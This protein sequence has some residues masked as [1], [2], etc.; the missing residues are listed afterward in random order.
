M[1]IN[2]S[3]DAICEPST[4]SDSFDEFIRTRN[5]MLRSQANVGESISARA[6]RVWRV[7]KELGMGFDGS[8]AKAENELSSLLL[9]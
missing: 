7:C 8:D 6:N 2:S 5:T 9:N 4:S 3:G 1:S